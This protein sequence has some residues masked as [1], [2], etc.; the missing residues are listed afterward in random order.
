VEGVL[1]LRKMRL[2]SM[3]LC[4]QS[5]TDCPSFLSWGG[6]SFS[7]PLQGTDKES[8]NGAEHALLVWE[9]STRSNITG[10]SFAEPGHSGRL[11]AKLG[12]EPT[13]R[14]VF[15]FFFFCAY[16]VFSPLPC[17]MWRRG[18]QIASLALGTFTAMDGVIQ[19]C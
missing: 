14:R 12:R 6:V 2:R 10:F 19:S 11:L 1:V 7:Q 9:K 15:F 4:V 13:T 18:V 16:V 3:R 17:S 5:S 8:A